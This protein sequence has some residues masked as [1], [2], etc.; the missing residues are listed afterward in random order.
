[1][2]KSG[3]NRTKQGVVWSTPVIPA[4]VWLSSGV[5]SQIQLYNKFKNQP[6]QHEILSQKAK[7]YDPATKC[8]KSYQDSVGYDKGCQIATKGRKEV[9]KSVAFTGRVFSID[10]PCSQVNLAC[11]KL[12]GTIQPSCLCNCLVFGHS[13]HF[14]F[15]HPGQCDLVETGH[16]PAPNVASD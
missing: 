3:F 7:T 16:I 2:W 15:S 4:W 13:M 10:V 6:E 14:F 8:I 12:T 11:V 1:M 5:Q 9:S